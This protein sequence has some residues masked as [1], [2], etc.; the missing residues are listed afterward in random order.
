[1]A[2]I[3]WVCAS[4]AQHFSRRYTANR[5]DRN[6][7]EGKGIIVSIL[8]YVVGRISGQFQSTNPLESR[9]DKQNGLL[10]ASKI[11]NN[12]FGPKVIADSTSHIVSQGSDNNIQDRASHNPNLLSQPTR[13]ADDNVTSTAD[14]FHNIAQRKLKLQEL[15]GLLYKYYHEQDADNIFAMCKFLVSQGNDDFLEQK[16][17]FLRNIDNTA[18]NGGN[19]PHKSVANKQ[20]PGM[21]HS[22]V[23]DFSFVQRWPD[24]KHVEQESGD[25]YSQAR[26][27][28]SEIE[29]VLSPHYPWET[30][31]NIIKGLVKTCNITGKY[32]ILDEALKRHRSNVSRLNM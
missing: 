16:L 5:H 1:M 32:D 14:P 28:L 22:H 8:D 21:P 7:H 2:A 29:Q 20:N 24:K 13:K 18:S 25:E 15:S 4:C 26:A 9:R 19:S 30:V 27:K 31:Q 11:A 10:F 3:N 6:L 17:T 12:N 23:S